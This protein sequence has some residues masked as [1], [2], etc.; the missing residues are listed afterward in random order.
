MAEI[1]AKLI[2]TPSLRCYLFHFLLCFSDLDAFFQPLFFFGHTLSTSFPLL[3]HCSLPRMFVLVYCLYD[4]F[5]CAQRGSFSPQTL[6]KDCIYT[7]HTL[8]LSIFFTSGRCRRSALS[9][10]NFCACCK[11]MGIADFSVIGR[12]LRY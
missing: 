9:L 4:S 11:K 7:V 10:F 5:D 6:T 1:I 8:T 12:T 3:P 2:L